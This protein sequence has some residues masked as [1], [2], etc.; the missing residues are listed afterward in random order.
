MAA[1]AAFYAVIFYGIDLQREAIFAGGT[2]A[3]F[4]T[5]LLALRF[6]LY[7]VGRLGLSVLL[8]VGVILFASLFGR[9]AGLQLLLYPAVALPLVCFDAR[10]RSSIGLAIAVT[11][12]AFFLLEWQNYEIFP[13]SALDEATRR[14]IYLAFSFTSFVLILVPVAFFA[15]ARRRAEADLRLTNDQLHDANNELV[16]AREG[17]EAANQA[18]S[19]F[20]ANMSH[21][22]RTPLNAIIGY[23]E[24]I[25]EELA[26]EGLSQSEADLEKIH[27]AGTHLLSIINDIL[28]L[29]KIEAGRIDV[30]WETF[31][32]G[33]LVR[34]V[35]A[36]L[37]PL[38]ERKG[39]TLEVELDEGAAQQALRADR[40]RL[41]QALFNL[42]SNANKFTDGG[43]VRLEVIIERGE[44]DV[45][46]AV[47]TVEDTGIGMSEE[48]LGGLFQ[49][50]NRADAETNRRYEGTGLGLTISRKLCRMMGGDITA[51]SELG[52]GSTFTL[53]I[54][55]HGGD[56]GDSMISGGMPMVTV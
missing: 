35:L 25:S 2:V 27:D 39:N 3:G 17:A 40:T 48:V 50:F 19:L 6:G 37:R 16:R 20:L 41:R 15:L 51:T 36:M 9:D 10:E 1:A 54:P 21:E 42:L 23:S 43:V 11:V 4:I 52:E 13:R 18:K 24:L 46:W 53:R 32:A 33:S 8:A 28:D 34:D 30:F 22:L 14:A 26:D 44:G 12:G 56:A 31:R 55:A 29:S 38:I 7:T 47:F 5:I 49:P 45:P